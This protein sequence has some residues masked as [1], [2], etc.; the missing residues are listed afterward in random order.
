MRVLFLDEMSRRD[1]KELNYQDC[2]VWDPNQCAERVNAGKDDLDVGAGVQDVKF[3]YA[4]DETHSIT[5]PERS[6]LMYARM[7]IFDV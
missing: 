1:S 3:R 2:E 4:S 7:A 6:C 5:L